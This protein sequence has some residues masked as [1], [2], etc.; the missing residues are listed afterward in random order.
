MNYIKSSGTFNSSNGKDLISYF[1]Y[2]PKTKVKAI[3]QLSHGMCEFVERY[4]GFAKFLCENGILFCG[5]DHLGHGRSVASSDDLG[6]FG[7]KDGYKF[8]CKDLHRFT[9]I[10]KKKYPN[11][12]YFLF[13]HSMGSFIARAYVAKFGNEIDGAIFCGT[14]GGRF[15]S[16]LGLVFPKMTATIKG[17]KYRSKLINKIAF[18]NYNKKFKGDE[19]GNSWLTR[20]KSLLERFTG[21]EFSNFTFTVSAFED[22]MKL[23]TFISSKYWYSLVPKELPIFLISGGDDPLGDYGKG[24]EKVYNKLKDNDVKNVSLKI[25]EGAR[26]EILNEINK[27]EVYEDILEF[28]NF[29]VYK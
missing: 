28:I 14:S 25:Y 4:R 15:L 11:T 7:D 16:F 23:L 20:D 8:L 1:I 3:F 2:T 10:M 5:N 27:E 22:L 19:N 13:G 18:M 12:P 6:Y 21:S 17:K 29:N 26:H 24:V 9:V